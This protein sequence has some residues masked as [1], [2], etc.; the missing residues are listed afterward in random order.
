ML[1]W[2]RHFEDGERLK[3]YCQTHRHEHLYLYTTLR[4]YMIRM[5][6][7]ADLVY[8]WYS[9]WTRKPK[10]FLTQYS[11]SH[12]VLTPYP[13]TRGK[14]AKK[15]FP[16]YSIFDRPFCE[17]FYQFGF[18]W[19]FQKKIIADSSKKG[20]LLPVN[21]KYYIP[22]SSCALRGNRAN[23]TNN[24]TNISNALMMGTFQIDTH[25]YTFTDTHRHYTIIRK[26]NIPC[27]TTYGL[28]RACLF[29][30]Q[31]SQHTPINATTTT[32]PTKLT[33]KS[34]IFPLETTKFP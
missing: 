33:F 16:H 24:V 27:Q 12:I 18:C 4:Y 5:F 31:H 14:S 13:S 26:A 21:S 15:N 11:S 23:S 1:I 3:Q 25:R 20:D 28:Y 30:H 17:K 9:Q 22:V 8:I 7:M 10:E 34:T 32:P 29:H 6:Q 19:N 2:Q